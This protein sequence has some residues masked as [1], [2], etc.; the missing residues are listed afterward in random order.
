MFYSI[1]NNN[2]SLEILYKN[3]FIADKTLLLKLLDEIYIE[4]TQYTELELQ[5]EQDLSDV[6]SPY[7]ITQEE[8]LYYCTKALCNCSRFEN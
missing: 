5:K 2:Q 4:H 3:I 8:R 1:F 6:Q 7:A